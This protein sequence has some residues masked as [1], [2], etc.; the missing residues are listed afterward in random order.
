[1]F[2]YKT[3]TSLTL[4]G[5]FCYSILPPYLSENGGGSDEEIHSRAIGKQEDHLTCDIWSK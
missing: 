2:T 5:Q 3:N 1:M 4:R